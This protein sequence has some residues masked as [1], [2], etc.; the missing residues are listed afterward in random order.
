MDLSESDSDESKIIV[1]LIYMLKISIDKN[2]YLVSQPFIYKIKS[3]S[4]ININKL[5][6]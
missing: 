1:D 3:P 5:L 6:S 2:L 4:A